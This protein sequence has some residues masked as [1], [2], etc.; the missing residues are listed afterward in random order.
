M[1]KKIKIAIVNSST[2]GKHYPDLLERLQRLGEIKRFQFSPE[3]E[4]EELTRQLEGYSFIVASVTPHFPRVL[5][6][7]NKDLLLLARHGIGV[8]NV[9]LSA[10][11]EHGVLVTRVPA[12]P[13]RDAVAE[14]NL[15]L[16]MACIRDIVPGANAS[17]RLD[18]EARSGFVGWE[19]SH[20]TVGVIGYGNI[21]SRVGEIIKE[22]FRTEV[23]AC[24]PNI[25]DAVLAKTGVEPVELHELLRRADVISINAS[26]NPANFQMIGEK[27]I[28]LMRDGVIIVNTAR[29][30]L[31]DENALA[32]GVRS[33]KIARLGVD[34]LQ[35]EP[36]LDNHPFLG[37]DNVIVLPHLGGYTDRSLHRMDEKNVEDIEYVL[38]GRIPDEIANPDVLIKGTRAELNR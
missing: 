33:G 5:F 11:T 25:A 34:V 15:A 10:A 27:E 20:L 1:Q 19:L 8:N 16:I 4:G 23:L 31:T 14:L 24:D 17:R 12:A 6:E 13:E 18:W 3:V 37:L 9:D 38:Q 28:G 30:E 7:K 32:E 26:H 29:G 22:G 36:I 2:F 21:G 35:R